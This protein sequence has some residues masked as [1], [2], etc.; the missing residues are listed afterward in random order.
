MRRNREAPSLP[1]IYIKQA[2]SMVDL[3]YEGHKVGRR[4]DGAGQQP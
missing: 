2:H 1:G 3:D 4:P